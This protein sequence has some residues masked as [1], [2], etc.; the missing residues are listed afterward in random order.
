MLKI[1]YADISKADLCGEYAL[2]KYRQERVN[3]QK[4]PNRRKAS[5][6]AEL[7]LISAIHSCRPDIQP[8]LDIIA[9]QYGKPELNNQDLHFSL[10]HSGDFI[11]AALCDSA[12]GVDIQKRAVYSTALVNRFFAEAERDYIAAAQ[13]KNYAFTEIWSLKES[14]I[15]AVGTGMHMPLNSFSVIE[16]SGLWHCQLGE[17]HLA[18]CVPGRHGVLPDAVEKIDH[19]E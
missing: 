10:S 9:G 5:I 1:F 3:S 4:L 12:V 16:M 15:K 14:Y 19:L 13:D 18:A 8:P 11:A 2:S 17:Y 7:L 6:A